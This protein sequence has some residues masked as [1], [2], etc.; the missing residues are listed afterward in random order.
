M[1][2]ISA[3]F[4]FFVQPLGIVISTSDLQTRDSRACLHHCLHYGCH[5]FLKAKF[6]LTVAPVRKVSRAKINALPRKS[7]HEARRWSGIMITMRWSAG[8]S[9]GGSDSTVSQGS[10]RSF[11]CTPTLFTSVQLGTNPKQAVFFTTTHK[12]SDHQQVTDLF[13]FLAFV[14]TNIFSCN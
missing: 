13:T 10:I 4:F 5:P 8:G 14:Y 12:P 2:C 3:A 1:A 6:S 7:R 9:L 11:P